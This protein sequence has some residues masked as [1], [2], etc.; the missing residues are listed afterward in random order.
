MH[1][2]SPFRRGLKTGLILAGV[3]ILAWLIWGKGMFDGV[4]TEV[5]NADRPTTSRIEST[6]RGSTRGAVQ[7]SLGEPDSTKGR[8]MT[9]VSR[10][11]KSF[12]L[13]FRQ[14]RLRTIEPEQE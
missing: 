2:R 8:C 10:D 4:F 6:D 1:Y 9:Y 13:C 3:I 14:G 11:E 12:R 5:K 7:K